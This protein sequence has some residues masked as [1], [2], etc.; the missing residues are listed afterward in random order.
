MK[1]KVVTKVLKV[2]DKT[3]EM[4]VEYFDEFKRD[5][6]PPYAILQADDGDT[7]V[8]LYESGK[9][10][11]Q[12]RDADLASDF[13]IETEKIN[14]G[15][16]EVTSSDNKKEEKKE[17]RIP[18][19]INSVGSDEVGTGDYFGPIVVTATYVDKS[20]IDF[21]LELGVKDSKKM[22][23]TE[24]K[25][26][27]PEIIKKIPYHTFIL[28][29][30]QYNELYDKNNM[31]KMKAILHNKVLSEFVNKEKYSYEYIVVDQFE[32]PKSYYN[33]LSEAKFKVY[34]ITFLTK[35]EDEC[36]SVACAS[37]IS[38]YIF[39]REMNNM[40]KNIGIDIPKGASDIVD[41][42]GREIVKKY[43]KDKLSEIAKLNFKNTEKII[44]K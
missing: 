36:L 26:V 43:G 35:A 5:K 9:C 29:N 20:N 23:D 7:V 32:N 42:V 15:K 13:W 22:S 10:V 8:T 16:A 33:H 44:N 38:R 17:R 19:R 40:S 3:K 1:E 41:N 11:F 30:K 24:I 37:L 21:L 28:N 34:G 4:M 39:L 25:K 12:G 6:T 18:L 27:V 31:N 2:S 14:S